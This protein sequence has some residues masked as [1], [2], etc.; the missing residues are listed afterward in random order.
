MQWADGC[1]RGAAAAGLGGRAASLVG[2]ALLPCHMGSMWTCQLPGS[3][4]RH[5]AH[6][7]Q[8]KVV[9]DDP[10]KAPKTP[11]DLHALRYQDIVRNQ[12]ASGC[13]GLRAVGMVHAGG[14]SRPPTPHRPTRAPPPCP[15]LPAAARSSSSFPIPA[16]RFSGPQNN[17][18]VLLLLLP[19]RRGRGRRA[20]TSAISRGTQT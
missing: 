10:S 19:P 1:R 6:C 17:R 9:H 8:D 13:R 15:C 2:I 14:C 7:P 4:P 5:S 16:S 12:C 20:G 11:V 18:S 3:D